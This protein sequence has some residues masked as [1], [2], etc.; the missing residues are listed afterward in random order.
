[1]QVKIFKHYLLYILLNLFSFQGYSETPS[2]YQEVEQRGYKHT[3]DSVW[4]P[5]GS[6]CTIAA[7]NKQTCGKEWYTEKSEWNFNFFSFW[8]GLLLP[9]AFFTY[10]S[11]SINK[12]LKKRH[13]KYK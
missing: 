2:F 5:D 3:A 8:I 1:M 9:F 10:L 13:Q 4:F 7:F 12:R 6:A 11:I